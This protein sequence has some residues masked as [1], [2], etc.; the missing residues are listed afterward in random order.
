MGK[1]TS[2]RTG[3]FAGTDKERA[4]DIMDM[5]GNK[6]VKGIFT[7]KGGWGCARI[8]PYLDYKIIREN[9][10]VLI[11]FSDITSLLNAVTYKSGL[12]T[13]HGPVGNSSWNEFS[14][15]SFQLCIIQ[16]KEQV[17]SLKNEEIKIWSPGKAQGAVYG[18]N[19]SVLCSMIGTPYFPKLA[20]TMLLLEE[21]TEEPF[22][23]DRMLT[24]LK[25]CGVLDE[26]SGVIFGRCTKCLAEEPENPR[27]L[28]ACIWP[29]P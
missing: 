26:L 25:Q 15:N 3:Y 16:K 11:G 13:F 4:A 6:N 8:L 7:A 18:G 1:T 20:G 14:V 22:R 24:Q 19:L 27:G 29:Y 12:V 2:F 17:I 9:P 10:K 23:I 28:R 5:F 21:T